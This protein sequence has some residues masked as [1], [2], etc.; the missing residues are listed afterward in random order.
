MQ[1]PRAVATCQ[2]YITLTL[3]TEMA[4]TPG[5]EAVTALLGMLSEACEKSG[6]Q[7][8]GGANAT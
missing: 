7:A 1:P 3:Y 2:Q 6:G 8:G 4:I 5:V